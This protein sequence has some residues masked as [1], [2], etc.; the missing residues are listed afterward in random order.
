[1]DAKYETEVG[2]NLQFIPSIGYAAEHT[3]RDTEQLFLPLVPKSFGDLSQRGGFQSL[4]ESARNGLGAFPDLG[5][6]V[7]PL[8]LATGE[9]DMDAFYLNAKFTMFENFDFFWG[10]R[11]E[12]VN[13]TTSTNVADG[14]DFFN[15][16]LLRDA[17]S[18]AT[19]TNAQINTQILGINGSQPLPTDFIGEIDEDVA[20]PSLGITYRPS[21]GA[22]LSLAYSE[23]LV[24]PSFKEFTFITVQNP[25]TLD[26][27]SGNPALTTSE[28]TSFDLRIEY[29][30]GRGDLF[31]FG[32]F[33]KTI[34]DPIEKTSLRGFAG[35]TDIFFNNSNQAELRGVEIE[36]R[37]TLDFFNNDFLSYFSVGGN[38][39]LIDATVDIPENFRKLLSGGLEVDINGNSRL[40]GGGAYAE[41]T[42]P[43]LFDGEFVDPPES[44]ALFQQP[45]WIVNA[46]VSFD[47]PEWGTRAALSLFAQSEVLDRAGGFLAEGSLSSVDEF[48]KSFHEINFTLSQ[49]LNDF[50]TLSFSVK[51]LTDSERGIEYDEIVGGDK[52]TFRVGRDYSIAITGSF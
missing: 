38:L 22:R 15:S 52:R 39:T 51:N 21:E 11:F 18:G 10:L 43:G 19:P 30:W 41:K 40:I 25:V 34:D 8:A 2:E 44:R 47:H 7:D 31:A 50:L 49:R 36:A 14:S 46:D 45:E 13:M 23:T 9:R 4:G 5:G 42:G 28:V 1:M 26:F 48:R 33:H 35:N 12:Q 3:E 27:E 37:K 20:L 29:T 17:S 32:A 6:G 24:R 16:D